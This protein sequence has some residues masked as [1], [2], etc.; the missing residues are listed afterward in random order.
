MRKRVLNRQELIAQIVDICHRL[1]AKGFV[2]ATDGNVSARLSG[3]RILTTRTGVPKGFVTAADIV[4]V[5]LDGKALTGGVRPSTEVGMHLFIYRRRPDVRAVV[6]AHPVAATGFAAARIALDRSV[7]PEIIIG[8]GT[9]PLAEYATPSTGEVAR[10][11]EPLIGKRDAILM[12]NHG[13]VTCGATLEEAYWNMEKV[14]HAARITAVARL[15]GG[16]HQLNEG[17]LGKLR[18]ISPQSFGRQIPDD[19]VVHSRSSRRGQSRKAVRRP[20]GGLRRQRR[21]KS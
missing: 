17:E 6:H 21:R 7:L 3:T 5:R 4:E 16:E 12:A 18:S 2:A 11:L 9:V 15:L 10:S 20:P 8:L 19:L 14:E 1:A 13:V